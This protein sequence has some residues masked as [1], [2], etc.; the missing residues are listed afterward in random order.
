[1]GR[2]GVGELLRAGAGARVTLAGIALCIL[3]GAAIGVVVAM[4]VTGDLA[5]T[6]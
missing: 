6:P 5:V 3:G 2:G 1:M 4:L